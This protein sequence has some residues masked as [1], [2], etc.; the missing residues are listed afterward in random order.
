MH[1]KTKQKQKTKC[2]TPEAEILLKTA[3]KTDVTDVFKL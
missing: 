2:E 3:H 1:R